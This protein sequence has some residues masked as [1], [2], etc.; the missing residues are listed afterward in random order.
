MSNSLFDDDDAGPEQ[1]K[2]MITLWFVLFLRCYGFYLVS[3]YWDLLFA[4]IK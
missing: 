2:L 3:L 1:L 4:D